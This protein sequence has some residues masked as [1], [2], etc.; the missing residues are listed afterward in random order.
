MC[1]IIDACS[2]ASV[3]NKE[4]QQHK[5]FIPILRWITVG[6]GRIVYGGSKYK[7][8]LR[9]LKQYLGI[10]LELYKQGRVVMI[11][12]KPVDRYAKK[13]KLELADQEFNDEHLV[14]I[15]AISRC[16]IVCTDDKKAHPYLQRRSLYPKGVKP[17][18]IYSSASHV[19][20]CCDKNIVSI[21]RPVE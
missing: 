20:L 10:I 7:A 3:F 6:N 11:P 13:I 4:A 12:D 21:C 15:V 18:K 8:E 5:S 19:K 1:V 17:P 2:V 9:R 14:A 16:H